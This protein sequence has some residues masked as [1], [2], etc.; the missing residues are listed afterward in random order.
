MRIT[1]ILPG[2]SLSGGAKVV[3]TYAERL[4]RRGHD[5]RVAYRKRGWPEP[6]HVRGFAARCGEQVR[7]W[8]AAEKDHLS[9]LS[10][11]RLIAA[12]AGRP[13]AADDLPDGE[14]VVA[15]WW[16]T[17]EWVASLPPSKG[18]PFYLIQ[19]YEVWGD[20]PERVDA[21]WRYPMQKIVVSRWLAYL[22]RGR[23]G[24]SRAVLIPNGVDSEQFFAPP[25]D[26]HSPPAIGFAYSTT[27]L[28]GIDV[29]LEVVR[30]VRQ[31]LP[32]LRVISFGTQRPDAALPLPRDTI[33]HRRP[34]QDSLRHIYSSCDVWLLTSRR[35]GFG[36]PALE[37][38]ACRCPVVA[39]RCGGPEDFVRDGVNGFLVDVDDVRG[40]ADRLVELLRNSDQLRR[41]SEAAQQTAAQFDWDRSTGLLEGVLTGDPHQAARK[42]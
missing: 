37:A 39:T 12:S 38:M 22:A 11:D 32:E 14:A 4:L 28:K 31:S 6:W 21:T 7:S 2:R 24:D 25:R 13:I 40:A 36:L 34:P 27:E 30:Q 19:G 23:F 29:V 5:V 17:A 42:R 3:A 35:E 15:T 1:F 10:G 9:C 26:P 33:F 16:E 8:L 41:F 20:H 18:R